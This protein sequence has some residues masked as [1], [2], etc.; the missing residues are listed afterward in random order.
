MGDSKE[1]YTYVIEHFSQPNSMAL[2]L[3]TSY[4]EGKQYVIITPECHNCALSIFK[5]TATLC[6]LKCDRHSICVADGDAHT[7]KVLEVLSTLHSEE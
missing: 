1:L 3:T 2:D 5:G 7:S 6:A 4:S